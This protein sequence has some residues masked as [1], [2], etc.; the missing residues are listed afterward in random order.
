MVINTNIQAISATRNLA[1]SQA[2]LGRSL[3]RL[4]SGFEDREALG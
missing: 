3:S 1:D 4:S 2:M